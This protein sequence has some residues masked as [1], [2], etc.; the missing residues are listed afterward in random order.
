MPRIKAL[1]PVSMLML[2][3]SSLFTAAVVNAQTTNTTTTSIYMPNINPQIPDFLRPIVEKGLG[4][5]YAIAWVG[6]LIGIG[7]GVV[8]IVV[9]RDVE[10]GKKT[11]AYAILG[12]IILAILP[13]FIRWLLGG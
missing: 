13:L 1:R 9:F 11:L 3:M 8:E 4:L 12:A 2:S 7:I 10:K 5:L 6:V